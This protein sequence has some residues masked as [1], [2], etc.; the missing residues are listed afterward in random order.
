MFEKATIAIAKLVESATKLSSALKMFFISLAI[1]IAISYIYLIFLRKATTITFW[2][3]NIILILFVTLLGGF[4]IVDNLYAHGIITISFGVV[5]T[6]IFLWNR[7]KIRSAADL[8]MESLKM[9]DVLP[10]LKYLPILVRFMSLTW[11]WAH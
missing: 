2:I 7:R 9:V 1:I 10:Q 3:S 5:L 11:H 8:I 6:A 4:T